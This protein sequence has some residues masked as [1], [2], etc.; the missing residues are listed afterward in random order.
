MRR[1]TTS[2]EVQRVRVTAAAVLRV[3]FRCRRSS[4][5]RRCSSVGISPIRLPKIRL[6]TRVSEYRDRRGTTEETRRPP[7]PAKRADEGAPLRKDESPIP[8]IS[9]LRNE[10]NAPLSLRSGEKTVAI[11]GSTAELLPTRRHLVAETALR[12][13]HYGVRHHTQLLCVPSP[14]PPTTVKTTKPAKRSARSP[15]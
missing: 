15:A 8:L 3:G 4:L 5:A 14:R 2:A 6:S 7:T 12:T 13:R 10:K 11:G 1:I 9:A